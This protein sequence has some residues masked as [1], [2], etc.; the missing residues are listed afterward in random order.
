[1]TA[2]AGIIPAAALGMWLT[3]PAPAG[4]H[5]LDEYLQTTRVAIDIDRVGL[6]IDLTPGTSMAA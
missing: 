1:M 3:F 5:R 4:A 2:R 6:D